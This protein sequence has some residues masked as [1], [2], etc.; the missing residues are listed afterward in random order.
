MS[1]ANSNRLPTLVAL[2]SLFF[3]T[4]S[5]AGP[6]WCGG[7]IKTTYLQANGNLYIQGSW[8]NLHHQICNMNAV[9]NGVEIGVCKGWLSIA[10]TAVVT[11][12]PVVVY[13]AEALGCNGEIPAYESS[14][15]PGYFMMSQ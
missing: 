12:K 8:D 1:R 3:S 4:T 10:E 9:W 6:Q 13:Y 5:I 15:A 2:A 14:P 11:A 7:T